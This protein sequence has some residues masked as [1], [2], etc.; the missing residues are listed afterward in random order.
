MKY[1]KD[2]LIVER[3]NTIP[4]AAHSIVRAV[5]ARVTYGIV[6]KSMKDHNYYDV[7]WFHRVGT[8]RQINDLEDTPW[9]SLVSRP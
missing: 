8:H 1:K 3:L 9:I 4:V 5:P 6:I 2:D 7:M